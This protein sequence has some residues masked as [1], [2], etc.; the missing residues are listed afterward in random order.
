MSTA[1]D[2]RLRLAQTIVRRDHCARFE[3]GDL[4]GGDGVHDHRLGIAE[5]VLTPRE[6]QNETVPSPNTAPTVRT[7]DST[8][9][10]K[11]IAS[12]PTSPVP[13]DP[14]ASDTCR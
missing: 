10:A 2:E 1:H 11:K 9:E 8:R 4:I 13:N 12:I 3:S 5:V 6:R 7:P 14:A